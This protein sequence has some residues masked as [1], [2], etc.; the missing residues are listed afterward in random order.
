HIFIDENSNV[1]AIEHLSD[2]Q[3]GVLY[4][5]IVPELK[6]YA[7]ELKK[8][9]QDKEKKK[10][11]TKTYE[12]SEKLISSIF[13]KE[14]LENLIKDAFDTKT[15]ISKEQFISS[16][17]EKAYHNQLIDI[18]RQVLED[19]YNYTNLVIPNDTYM[20]EPDAD[21]RNEAKRKQKPSYS[22]V[23]TVVENLNQHEANFVGKDS[24]GIV[25]LLN[26]V[27]PQ[28]QKVGMYLNNT[29]T[30]NVH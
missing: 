16:Y 6:E 13:G 21:Q 9:K 25:T 19:S 11:S 5:S 27:F 20:F 10:K 7:E 14:E 1:R 24:L 26:K 15:I 22:R 17:K 12:S 3:I 4:D 23:P 29:Y 28:L 8:I 30:S 2:H 18:Q